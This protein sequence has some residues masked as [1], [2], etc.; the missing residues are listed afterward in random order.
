MTNAIVLAVLAALGLLL[1]IALRQMAARRRRRSGVPSGRVL[2]ADSG[3]VHG[4]LLV[5]RSIALRGR[6]D[7][8]LED[9]STVIPVEVKTGRTP[10]APYR[11]H[12]M[13]LLAYCLLVEET[14]GVRPPHGILRYPEREFRIAYDADS[15]RELRA[16]IG[17]MLA[18]KGANREQHRSHR[19]ARRCSACGY[20]D[21][22]AERLVGATVPGE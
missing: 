16:L 2:F 17:A 4:S 15:E 8:L 19:Q 9:G 3:E 21:R 22:C 7:L 18:E 1:G 6:P 13:Q 10:E 14:H 5:A 20:R 12:T 11:G